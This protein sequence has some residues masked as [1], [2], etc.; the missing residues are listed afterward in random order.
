MQN[1]GDHNFK[2]MKNAP[3]FLNIYPILKMI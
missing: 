2:V 1:R 3:T